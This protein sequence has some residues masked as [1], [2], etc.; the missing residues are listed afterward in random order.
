MQEHETTAHRFCRQKF[1][2]NPGNIHRKAK[3][4]HE[5]HDSNHSNNN[6]AR[7]ISITNTTAKILCKT[8][9]NQIQQCVER[10]YMTK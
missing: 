4:K 2:N 9:A 6:K 3:V 8:S 10:I 7:P 1:K 5:K